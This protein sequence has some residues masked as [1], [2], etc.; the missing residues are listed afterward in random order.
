[1]MSAERTNRKDEGFSLIEVMVAIV[2]LTVGL[3]SLAQMMVVATNSNSLSGRMTSCSALAKEQLERLKAA[4]FYTNPQAFVRNPMLSAG[5]DIA[6][7]V[8]GFSQLYDTEGLP[9][10]GGPGMYEVRWQI[11]DVAT[12]LPLAMVRIQVRCL[13]ASGLDQ[14]AVIGEARF[15]T[16]RTANVG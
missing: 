4:P 1:M 7:T 15:T 13:A 2:I 8:S 16:F 11:A 14:F 6:N 3:L 10:A 9:M 12:P 5:G